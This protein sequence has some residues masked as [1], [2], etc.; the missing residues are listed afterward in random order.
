M[1]MYIDC[2]EFVNTMDIPNDFHINHSIANM[3]IWLIYQRL[4]DFSENKFAFQLREELIEMFNKMTQEEME[5]V[6]VLRKAKKI[7]DIDNY[8][9]AIRRNFDFHFFINGKSVDNPYYKLDAL[10]WSCIFH[11]KVPRYSDQVYRMSEYF[12][13]HFKYLK[14]VSF[15]DIEKGCVDWSAYR[16]PFNY[17]NKVIRVNP[18]LGEEEFEK[19]HDSPYK[20]KKYHYSFRREQ[21]LTE[22]NLIKTYVNLCTN[23]FYHNKEKTVRSENLNLDAMNSEEKELMIYQMKRELEEMSELPI[24]NESF[25]SKVN[26]NPTAQQFS[27]W[28]RNLFVPLADQLEEQAKRKIAAIEE[29]RLREEEKDLVFRQ[30]GDDRGLHDL[31]SQEKKTER[32]QAILRQHFAE[33]MEKEGKQAPDHEKVQAEFEEREAQKVTDSIDRMPIKQKRKWRVW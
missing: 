26:F 11:E 12:I 8:M 22:E 10:V 29:A 18:P 16:V 31:D 14:S 4:R 30:A 13:Q 2:W 5:D 3:H 15:T 20:V 33:E 19:E 9:Y 24:Q 17:Q 6:D 27:I 23:A 32:H 25:F 7:E 21:E 28:K 1:L